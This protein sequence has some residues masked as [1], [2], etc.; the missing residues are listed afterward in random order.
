LLV[1]R[2]TRFAESKRLGDYLS[3]R[4]RDFLFHAAIFAAL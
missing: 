1:K 3:H 4:C 2:P